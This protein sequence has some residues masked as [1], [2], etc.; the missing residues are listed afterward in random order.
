MEQR[1]FEA[2]GG[3]MRYIYELKKNH[4]LLIL[5]VFPYFQQDKKR[6]K[7]FESI[8]KRTIQI[9]GG[10]LTFLC[11]VKSPELTE[12]YVFRK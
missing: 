6:F 9:P 8:E 7:L 5:H 11:Y 2:V 4:N 10:Q 1:R 3:E 12:D